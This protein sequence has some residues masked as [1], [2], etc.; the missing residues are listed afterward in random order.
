MKI[1][2]TLVGF[3]EAQE[4]KIIKALDLW[5]QVWSSAEFKMEVMYYRGTKPSEVGFAQNKD[6]NMEVLTKLCAV[7]VKKM[8]YELNPI[9]N[10]SETAS[11][12]TVTGVTTI[13]KQY[14]DSCTIPELVNTLSHESTHCPDQGKYTHSYLCTKWMPWTLSR[15]YSVP[16]GIGQ[17]TEDL[18]TKL[19]LLSGAV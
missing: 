6:C 11:T 7:M 18:I 10:G 2:A 15:P 19:N 12:N 16:Y 1:T 4:D 14:L 5:Q 8:S 17:I 13:Q 9:P 3:T